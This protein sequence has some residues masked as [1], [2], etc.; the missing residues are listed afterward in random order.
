MRRIPSAIDLRL[1][2]RLLYRQPVLTLTAALSLAAGI[3][4]AAVGFAFT[5]VLLFSRLPFDGGDRFVQIR[6]V[7]NPQHPNVSLAPHDYRRLREQAT[8]FEHLGV[9]TG[10][11]R[12]VRLPSGQAAVVT[13]AGITPSSIRY[14]PHGP[15]RGRLL[16]PADAEPGA[17]AAVMVRETFWR[18]VLADV[19]GVVGSTIE[20]SGVA[21]TIVGVVPD[22]FE[23]PNSPDLW[24]PL[25][26]AFLQGRAV[27]VADARL[28]GI[29]APGRSLETARAQLSAIGSSLDEPV[30]LG[31]T[32]FTD[33]GPFAPALSS[34]VLAVVLAVLVV[35]AANVGNLILARSFARAREFALRAAL[36]ASR[37]RLV[38]Q[39]F[40]EVLLMGAVAALLGSASARAVLRQ[41][42]AMDEIPFWADFTGGAWTM[43]L[44]AASTVLTAAVAGAWPALR[45]TRRDLVAA[46]QAGEGRAT[47][48]R[49]GRLAGAAIVVQ[50]ALS[51]VMLHGAF[52]VSQGFAQYSGATLE[53]PRNVLTAFIAV[54]T[55]TDGRGGMTPSEVVE[56]ASALPGVAAAGL[57][58]VLPRHSP[59]AT[60]VEVEPLP[61]VSPAAPQ[62]APFAA[63]SER[64]FQVLEAD[65]RAGRFF[66]AADYGPGA[67][68]VAIV[69][70]PFVQKFFG[71]A[72]PVGRR[73]RTV[74]S[75]A[76]RA[77]H[78]IV[79]VVPDLGL[80]VGDP[81]F[82]AGYYVPLD[83]EEAGDVYL[84]MRVAG[85]P[86]AFATPLR[87]ALLARD[88]QLV[89]NRME[90]LEDVASEDRLFFRWFSVAL[91]GLGVVTLVLALAGVYAMMSLVVT[92]RTRE[93]GIRVALG[94]TS[95]RVVGTIVGRAAW[96][97][98]FGGAIGCGLAVLS[99]DARAI[100]VS[101][102]GDGG[103]WT[104]PAVVALLVGSG[105]AA[106]WMP[107]QRALRVRPA[108]ALRAE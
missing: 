99:L 97:V 60:L 108:E 87:R 12:N 29:L 55:T 31:V 41:F 107:L 49:F 101:R 45:A 20:V 90:R 62:P 76:H 66:E 71:G 64:F 102:L 32:R 95:V 42:N 56:L 17:T 22:A 68:P 82:A 36:G 30:T 1:A 80:S 47:D 93:I 35:I 92:R 57:S 58:T 89:I 2:V 38:G 18:N 88:P 37:G 59:E 46:L 54:D 74:G 24:I 70:E 96:L 10:G 51:V 65:L 61:G 7:Q 3:G 25:D 100:L 5:E 28:F 86:V 105:L 21:R 106:T 94:A 69:N 26:E 40:L 81:S 11:R 98:A 78:L 43:G 27:P 9:L 44:V 84:A 53:L 33:L 16:V 13:A 48:V 91:V 34:A 19:E 72:P 79:G 73:F 50:I 63:V 39:V 15:V 103:P 75:N 77:W 8:Y 83:P 6:L 14:L 52:I 67:P 85:D 104:L 4:L 23:F